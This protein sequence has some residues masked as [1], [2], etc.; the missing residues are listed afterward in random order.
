[1]KAPSTG[2]SIF[3]PLPPAL[4][5]V[6]GCVSSRGVA[7]PFDRGV[8]AC[9]GR[10]GDHLLGLGLAFALGLGILDGL[11]DLVSIPDAAHLVS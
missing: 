8:C 11:S 2:F 3:D 6:A 10:H 7:V 9:R 4:A 5:I 1:M